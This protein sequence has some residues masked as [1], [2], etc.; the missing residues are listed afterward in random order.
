VGR[1]GRSGCSS[2]TWYAVVTAR[3]ATL[4]G[5]VR[6]LVS[7][8]AQALSKL[9]ATGLACLRVPDV[10]PLLHD[11]TTSSSLAIFRRLRQAQQ[12]V[13]QAQARRATCRESPP[14]GVAVQQARALVEAQAAA[15][16]RWPQGR[17]A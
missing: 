9:A 8:R 14:G 6:S 5:G 1:S 12:A 4:G 11:L 16:Q 3:L 10:F 15:V 13:R 2:D 17:R 7:A